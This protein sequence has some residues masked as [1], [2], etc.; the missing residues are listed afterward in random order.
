M[1][2]GRSDDPQNPCRVAASKVSLPFGSGS[3]NP[4][5]PAARAATNR[6]DTRPQPHRS[7]ILLSHPLHQGAVHTRPTL[8]PSYLRPGQLDRILGRTLVIESAESHHRAPP[9]ARRQRHLLSSGC[10]AGRGDS[11]VGNLRQ[12]L[13][14]PLHRV[15][16]DQPEGQGAEDQ[17]R[18]DRGSGIQSA[19]VIASNNIVETAAS[20]KPIVSG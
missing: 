12:G 9:R 17:K 11:G 10:A 6:P 16:R 8:A 15:G 18:D 2:I 7:R 13:H 3:R 5:G 1:L 20:T 4:S 14:G 19:S